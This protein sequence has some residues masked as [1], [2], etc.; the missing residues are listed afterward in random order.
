[1]KK[2]DVKSLMTGIIIGAIGITTAFASGG[3][4]SASFSTSKLYLNGEEIPLKS[5]LVAIVKDGETDAQ[6]YMPVRESLEHLNFT[7]TWHPEVNSVHIASDT[8]PTQ[9]D[10]SQ[11]TG[12]I[13]ILEKLKNI[14]ITK[15][16][17][18]KI[19]VAESNTL[20]I[21]EVTTDEVWEKMNM[22]IFYVSDNISE[23]YVLY[24]NN[25]FQ[26]LPGN[27]LFDGGFG[28][29]C[30]SD[31][32]SNGEYELLSIFHAGSG[33]D[34][35][36][37]SCYIP[38]KE[39]LCAFGTVNNRYT[40][41]KTDDQNVFIKFSTGEMARINL[42]SANNNDSILVTLPE[43]LSE[44]MKAAILSQQFISDFQGISQ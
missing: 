13:A 27:Y 43:N 16:A 35:Q 30:V 14:K 34:Y 9:N 19:S 21:K 36:F 20:N 18:R 8:K 40:L 26:H 15:Q 1:M 24:R 17:N 3:I 22:Q 28:Q 7:V 10:K 5:P 31:L 4:Q 32:D 11:T 6:L 41:T 25:Q 12:S 37:L 39:V 44:E 29:F 23:A 33:V 2:F 38:E 42:M